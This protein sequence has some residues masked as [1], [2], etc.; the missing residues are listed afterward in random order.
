MEEILSVKNV[1]KSFKDKQVL[2]DICFEVGKGEVFC[3]LGPNGAGKSTTINILSSALRADTGSVLYKQKP[4]SSCIREYKQHLGIVPQDISLY[5][6]LSSRQNLAFFGSLYGLRGS[7]LLQA[8]EWALAFSGLEDR[9]TDKVE[10]LS[11]GMKRRLNIACAIV[12]HPEILIMDEP[13][14]GLDPQS[15]NHILESIHHLREQGMTILYTTHYMEE[16]EVISTR[17]II[18]DYGKIIASG[19]KESLISGN[20]SSKNYTIT[21]SDEADLPIEEFRDI[22]GVYSVSVQKDKMKIVSEKNAE[23]LDQIITLLYRNKVSIQNIG[24]ENANLETVFLSL[25]GRQLRD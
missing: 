23:N 21:F 12:H 15:R 9:Q 2:K 22:E 24:S 25:T 10:I 5:E 7:E 17:I 6:K 19:T 18:I 20:L 4:I 11:G 8:V 1:N 13:T 16:V 14:V 3:M